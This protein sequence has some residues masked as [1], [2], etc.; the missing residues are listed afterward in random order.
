MD[1]SVN[2]TEKEFNDMTEFR[3]AIEMKAVSIIAERR[4]E[5]DLSNVEAAY[6]AMKKAA[7]EGD[8]E[9]YSLQDYNF[10]F[11]ILIAS[12]NE[13]FIPVSY[14]HLSRRSLSIFLW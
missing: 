3:Q 14:T 13:L 12:G 6:L 7:K 9:E 2:L 1:R 8:E 11:S 5:I 10:H 4:D